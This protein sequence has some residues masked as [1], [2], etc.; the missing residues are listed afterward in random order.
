MN[1]NPA[2]ASSFIGVQYKWNG[3]R[4][5]EIKNSTNADDAVNNSVWAFGVG[6]ANGEDP[7][8]YKFLGVSQPAPGLSRKQRYHGTVW[9]KVDEID[10]AYWTRGPNSRKAVGK[11]TINPRPAIFDYPKGKLNEKTNDFCDNVGTKVWVWQFLPDKDWVPPMYVQATRDTSSDIDPADDQKYLPQ[12]AAWSTRGVWPGGAPNAEA[13]KNPFRYGILRVGIV[14]SSLMGGDGG[15]HTYKRA[16]FPLYARKNNNHEYAYLHAADRKSALA[17][18]RRSL[19]VVVVYE[20]DFTRNGLMTDYVKQEQT[21]FG[22]GGAANPRLAMD[23]KSMPNPISLKTLVA[24][25]ASGTPAYATLNN[26]DLRL[27]NLEKRIPGSVNFFDKKISNQLKEWRFRGLPK[28]NTWDVLTRNQLVKTQHVERHHEMSDWFPMAIAP[29]GNMYPNGNTPFGIHK[30]FDYTIVGNGPAAAAG[31]AQAQWPM[32]NISYNLLVQITPHRFRK[33]GLEWMQQNDNPSYVGLMTYLRGPGGAAAAAGGGGQGQPPPPPP[34]PPPVPPPPPPPPPPP[35]PPPG[36]GQGPPPPPPGGD[37]DDD[38]L[39]DDELSLLGQSDTDRSDIDMNSDEFDQFVQEMWADS[40]QS[41]ANMDFLLNNEEED[42]MPAD[43]AAAAARA[44]AGIKRRASGGGGSSERGSAN[45][46]ND[47]SDNRYVI[48]VRT[49]VTHRFPP[50]K[51]RPKDVVVKLNGGE[52]SVD[53]IVETLYARDPSPFGQREQLLQISE[54]HATDIGGSCT[55]IRILD[56]SALFKDLDIFQVQK[57][58]PYEFTIWLT[59]YEQGQGGN[60]AYIK[61]KWSM[62]YDL[63]YKIYEQDSARVARLFELGTHPEKYRLPLRARCNLKD[64]S[65]NLDT[66]T[67]VEWFVNDYTPC[68]QQHPLPTRRTPVPHYQNRRDRQLLQLH[69]AW[70]NAPGDERKKAIYDESNVWINAAPCDRPKTKSDAQSYQRNTVTE[71][72]EYYKLF[73]VSPRNER[74]LPSSMGNRVPYWNTGTGS[75]KRVS[76]AAWNHLLPNILNNPQFKVYSMV[77]ALERIPDDI[78]MLFGPVPFDPGPVDNRYTN[79]TNVNF[80]PQSNDLWKYIEVMASKICSDC[81]LPFAQITYAESDNRELGL[82]YVFEELAKAIYCKAMINRDTLH[83]FDIIAECKPGGRVVGYI[84]CGESKMLEDSVCVHAVGATDLKAD[85]TNGGISAMFNFKESPTG[86]LKGNKLDIANMENVLPS[87]F[88]TV[89][90]KVAFDRAIWANYKNMDLEALHTLKQSRGFAELMIRNTNRGVINAGTARCFVKHELMNPDDHMC[91]SEASAGSYVDDFGLTHYLPCNFIGIGLGR[92][93]DEEMAN[94]QV[95]TNFGAEFN[96]KSLQRIPSVRLIRN[97]WLKGFHLYDM[98]AQDSQIKVTDTDRFYSSLCNQTENVADQHYYKS[99]IE[100]AIWDGAPGNDVPAWYM[101]V[102]VGSVDRRGFSLQ[103]QL[104]KN[105]TNIRCAPYAGGGIKRS[106]ANNRGLFQCLLHRDNAHR[107]WHGRN[108]APNAIQ[109]SWTRKDVSAGQRLPTLDDFN[110]VSQLPVQ[111]I[112]PRDNRFF[113]TCHNPLDQNPTDELL[114]RKALSHY[115]TYLLRGAETLSTVLNKVH[116]PGHLH[117]GGERGHAIDY[118][119]FGNWKLGMFEQ[120]VQRFYATLACRR[121]ALFCTMQPRTDWSERQIGGEYQIARGREPKCTWMSFPNISDQNE[122]PW[123]GLQAEFTSNQQFIQ[124]KKPNPRTSDAFTRS[125]DFNNLYQ[126]SPIARKNYNKLFTCGELNDP[127]GL[128]WFQWRIQ[129]SD[130]NNSFELFRDNYE[131]IGCTPIFNSAVGV[132]AGAL[133]FIVAT[134]TVKGWQKEYAD[135]DLFKYGSS[136]VTGNRVYTCKTVLFGDLTQQINMSLTLNAV[137]NPDAQNANVGFEDSQDRYQQSLEAR[138][139]RLRP[140]IFPNKFK[141]NRYG[142]DRG[143]YNRDHRNYYQGSLLYSSMNVR[144]QQLSEK[145]ELRKCLLASSAA[146][147]DTLRREYTVQVTMLRRNH[148]IDGLAIGVPV[149]KENFRAGNYGPDYGNWY[150][151]S[152]ADC[153]KETFNLGIRFIRDYYTVCKSLRETPQPNFVVGGNGARNDQDDQWLA[154]LYERKDQPLS[155]ADEIEFYAR[156][157][158]MPI[159]NLD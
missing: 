68:A 49:P 159:F 25:W 96:M 115:G 51:Q 109:L 53:S 129:K 140:R 156:M 147:Y 99:S 29:N 76:Y 15:K 126:T 8:K 40:S 27:Q 89:L 14:Y 153:S 121:E 154:Q 71:L 36:G 119:L 26:A 132:S 70:R 45:R 73:D 85:K 44:S 77:N 151:H 74:R 107:Y 57:A 3:P 112:P 58:T 42:E 12:D 31:N 155:E 62:P 87:I 108:G 133:G 139:W 83:T 98:N 20:F 17:D 33:I 111:Q 24:R 54:K 67:A 124:Q 130:D 60:E 137:S 7:S 47:P 5:S 146:D 16:K 1:N 65:G 141:M 84:S 4:G 101:K 145:T 79:H 116:Q 10:I 94:N 122:N 150:L 82:E 63:Y 48:H 143:V 106:R 34:P 41:R 105:N 69:T 93:W 72:I 152:T 11:Q 9:D 13:L 64:G 35:N 30:L 127:I 144:Q 136:G 22:G 113:C 120:P 32:A 149:F 19:E 81:S 134:H 23:L 18:D 138:T 148:Q 97:Y 104:N 100:D 2:T 90:F 142:N 118:G 135:D 92:N 157:L 75:S 102:P 28:F 125:V 123:L 131:I 66:M 80:V 95:G 55:S 128:R 78:E 110:H 38:M 88:S 39:D 59:W 43:G 6:S 50:G 46:F 21:D 117:K 158:G 61:K 91:H 114:Q 86:L 56:N 37:D 52:F 103:V